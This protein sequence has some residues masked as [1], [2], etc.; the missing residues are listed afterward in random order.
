M[1]KLPNGW[2]IKKLKDILADEKYSIKRG[3]FGSSLRKE[4]F[5]K[6]GV[7]VF[8]Q[9]NTINNDPNWCRYRID[10]NK[11]EEL[12]A[13][14]CR[15]G[16]FLISCSGTLG[17]IILLPENVEE[18]IIN[19]ALLK[20][21]LNP[22][23][24]DNHYFL[25]LFQYKDFQKRIYKD[26]GGSAIHNIASVNTLKEMDVILPPL[27]EQKR[28]ASALSKI[29]AYLENTIK[30][31]EE[32]ERFKEGIAKKLLTC[33]EGEN[34]PE[35]R[36]KEFNDEWK[37]IKLGDMFDNFT[38]RNNEDKIMLASTRDKGVIPN[39]LTER[40]IIRKKESLSNYKLVKKGCFV[41]SLMS[42]QGGFEYSDYEGI[43]SPAYTVL[44]PKIEMAHYFY[45]YY[46]KSY[47]FIKDLRPYAEGIR[48]GKQIKFNACKD[49]LV[50]YPSMKEQENIGKLLSLL[51]AEI[52]NLKEQKEEI[53]KM[54]SGIINKL[55]SGEIKI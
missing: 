55:M 7:R 51:D 26:A 36:F 28:I 43:I 48:H 19:Q 33:K 37:I 29:D 46:F 1:N 3:P 54:K 15:A 24:I 50:P 47:K 11:Y 16:D 34:V 30:L 6:E 52:D 22:K 53:K 35:M 8:E 4:F 18:G 17:K 25:N 12:K 49:I 45:K 10:K 41:I 23:L 5:V 20:I 38:E 32:K 9:Y 44:K 40:K 21:R 31:I 14:K 39:N 13:F 42:F 27:D 2:Q